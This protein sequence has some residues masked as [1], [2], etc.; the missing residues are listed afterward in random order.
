M[1]KSSSLA[2]FRVLAITVLILFPDTLKA[3][4]ENTHPASSQYKEDI[5]QDGSQDVRDVMFLLRLGLESPGDPRADYDA[6]GKYSIIDAVSMLINILGQDLTPL[7]GTTPTSGEMEV[8]PTYNAVGLEIPYTGEL[9]PSTQVLL[10][11]RKNANPRWRNGVDMTVDSGRRLVW[12]SIYPLEPDEEIDIRVLFYDPAAPDVPPIETQAR[13]RKMV[14][15]PTGGRVFYVSPSG[16]DQNPGTLDLPLKTLAYAAGT[17]GPGD[18]VFALDGVYREG[19]LC[20]GLK[21]T[22]GQPVL[23]AAAEGHKPILDSSLEIARDSGVWK[24]YSGQVYS[25]ALNP[26]LIA[27]E[28]AG[29]GYLAQDGQRMF[30]YTTLADLISDNLNVPRAWYYNIEQKRLY[31]RTGN[32]DSPD[33]YTYNLAQHRYA[34]WLSGSEYVIV[35]GFEMR[36]YGQAAVRISEGAHG[37]LVTGNIIHNAP[38]GIYLKNT[39]TRDN[40][41]WHNEIY[42]PGLLEI[43]W[44]SIKAGEYPRQGVMSWAAGRGNSFNYNTVHGWFDGITVESWEMPDRIE[45]HRDTDVMYNKIFNIGDDAFEMDGGGVNMRLH[46]NTVRNA[47][48]AISLAPIERGPAYVT[49]NDVTFMNIMFKLNVGSPWSLGWTYVYHN[50]GYGL[51]SANGMA[52][53]G[54]TGVASGGADTRNKVFK[55]NA[56]I[57]ADRAVRTGFDGNYLDYNSYYHTPG[58]TPRKYEWNGVTYQTLDEFRT[59]TGQEAHGLYVDPQ[60]VDTPGLGETPWK[61]YW[62]DEMGNYPLVPDVT[63][64]NLHLSPGSPVIDRG[65]IIRGVNEDYAGSAPDI[66][67]FEYRP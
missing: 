45:V 47:M 33:N 39:E 22:A 35:Q 9:N 13:T 2:A 26:D 37:C 30:L 7:S 6:D 28:G 67:A 56:M 21:G 63:V 3:Y 46:G 8:F 66:G 42:E 27:A 31:V 48:V 54:L 52:M 11:W 5:N 25:A 36:Y 1:F 10:F 38:N 41:V 53:I 44:N 60:F 24:Q 34:F 50:S 14:T 64:G 61:G 55:N 15:E 32:N 59:A 49:R 58:L 65:V 23:F 57:G 43:P 20:Q 51:N 18:I 40:A 4:A 62:E 16:D 12:A 17:A 29:Y 19:D